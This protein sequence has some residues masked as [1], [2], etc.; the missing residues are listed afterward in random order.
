M[1]SIIY[2][3]EKEDEEKVQI[4]LMFAPLHGNTSKAF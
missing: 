3:W 1:G 2:V 4:G